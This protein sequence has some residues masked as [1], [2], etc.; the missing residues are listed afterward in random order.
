MVRAVV[1]E[2]THPTARWRK[3]IKELA[4]GDRVALRVAGRPGRYPSGASRAA[5]GVVC[6]A[7]GLAET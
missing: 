6:D 5:G 7:P 3:K 1:R 4:M 2:V